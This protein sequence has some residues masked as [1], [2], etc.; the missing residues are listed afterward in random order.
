MR[1]DFASRSDGELAFPNIVKYYQATQLR[2]ITFL[3]PL[4]SYNKWTEI[5]KIWLAPIHPNSL[6]WNANAEVDPG[7]LLG[8]MSEISLRFIS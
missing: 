8:S 6:L 7:R 5:E 3:V 1:Q 2:A 4:G